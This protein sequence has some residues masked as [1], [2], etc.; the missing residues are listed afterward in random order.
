M[1]FFLLTSILF[2]SVIAFAQTEEQNQ[3]TTKVLEEVVVKA[4]RSDRPLKD[5]PVTVNVIDKKDLN[6]FGPQ[7]MVTTVNTVPGVRIE[8]RSPGSYR[9]SIRGSVL[10]SPFGIRNVKFYWKGLPFTDGGG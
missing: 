6:R 4:Y 10:R 1:R 3:D 8:E 9:F 7:S 2:A 5:V